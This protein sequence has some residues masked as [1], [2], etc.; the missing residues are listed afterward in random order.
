MQRLVPLQK[1]AASELIVMPCISPDG[2]PTASGLNTLK[3]IKDGA[4]TP[5]EVAAKTG[6]PLFKVRSG[7][8]ELTTA[9]FATE[10]DGKFM[11]SKNGADAVQ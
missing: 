2:K 11:L 10:A 4:S 7:L 9:G 8:R 1:E 5:E 6:Q 3:A